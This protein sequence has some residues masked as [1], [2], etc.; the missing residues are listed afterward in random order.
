MEIWE[1]DHI[2]GTQLLINEGT[3]LMHMELF[4]TESDQSKRTIST[5]TPAMKEIS[6]SHRSQTYNKRNDYT[7]AANFDLNTPAFKLHFQ[8][9]FVCSCGG[10][11]A[12]TPAD[13]ISH[14]ICD[15]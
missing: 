10:T 7:F 3:L 9:V 6:H 4:I 2:S 5:K 1:D 15:E 13:T 14:S 8:H 11:A 12:F